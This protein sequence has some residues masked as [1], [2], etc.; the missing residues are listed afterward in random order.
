MLH[1]EI[2]KDFAINFIGLNNFVKN[3]QT[4]GRSQDL[5]D[6]QKIQKIQTGKKA[7]RKQKGGS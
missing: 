7:P 2:E 4:S 6:I 1:L 5:A 3:K